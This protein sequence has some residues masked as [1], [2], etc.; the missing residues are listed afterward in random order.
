MTRKNGKT[1]K[2]KKRTDK[3]DLQGVG[4]VG[5]PPVEEGAE[6]DARDDEGQHLEDGGGGVAE[7]GDEGALGHDARL[8][9]EA[10]GVA[11]HGLSI[12]RFASDT[13]PERTTFSSHSSQMARPASE[14]LKDRAR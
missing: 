3:T 7:H 5:E 10:R 1:E 4:P 14:F 2:R 13:Q 6:E 9:E 8:V 11:P 12:L